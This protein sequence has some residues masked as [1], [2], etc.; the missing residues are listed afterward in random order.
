M[1]SGDAILKT[2]PEML[3]A[4]NLIYSI[5]ALQMARNE[6]H[7]ENNLHWDDVADFILKFRKERNL[8]SPDDIYVYQASELIGCLFF[9]VK[10]FTSIQ[11]VIDKI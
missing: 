2:D 1:I 6:K 10:Y 5:N 3:A 8:C 9:S 11:S 4:G 7:A